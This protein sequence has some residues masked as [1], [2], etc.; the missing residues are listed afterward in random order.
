MSVNKEIYINGRFLS[1]KMDGISRFSL[2]ICKQLK[3]RN[4]NFKIIV[5]TWLEYENN[6][7]FKIVKTGNLKSH[8]WEQIDLQRFLKSQGSPLLV[9][10]SGLGPIFYK[11]QVITIHDLSF[12]ANKKWF[13]KTY[14][15]FYRNATPILARNAIKILSVSNF[16]KNEIVKYLKVSEKK[17]EVIYNAV[18]DTINPS[19]NNE[20]S[21]SNINYILDYKYI[22]AVCSIDPRKNLQRLIDSFSELNLPD[23]KLVLVGKKSNHFNVKLKSDSNNIIFAGFVSD[24][25]LAMLY[26]NCDFFIYPSLYEGFGIPP[27]EAMY[28]ESATIVSD[29]PSLREVCAD[30]AIYVNPYD[31]ESIKKGILKLIDNSVLKEE[32]RIKGKARSTFFK[33]EDSGEKVYNLIK[34][35]AV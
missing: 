34:N 5:P 24:F 1:H 18:S 23:I 19:R 13:S 9:N 16:S 2:E 4:L 21:T 30:A 25:E 33:W 22:L 35:I 14:T 32:M 12:Y 7:D 31:T 27:L 28:K 26:D 8:F 6:E 29:I 17:I 10:F 15:F 11:N 20:I 3:K